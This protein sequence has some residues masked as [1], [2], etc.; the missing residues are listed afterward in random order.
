MSDETR[1]DELMPRE[2]ELQGL[3]PRNVGS[4]EWE[5][6]E[7]ESLE[8][9]LRQALGYFK[10]SVHGWSNE[11]WSQA[12]ESRRRAVRPVRR[13]VWRLAAAWSLASLLAITAVSGVVYERHQKQELAQ[14]EHDRLLEQQREMAEQR[15][16]AEEDLLA[17]VES[18]ISR[19]V[20][21][22]ME[23][24]AQLMASDGTQ[25][26]NATQ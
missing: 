25:T 16:R 21:S 9:E 20:P 13:R 1:N 8:P 17:K 23:P 10:A 22:A 14:I 2:R 18:D 11:V 24:L 7:P 15:Q 5:A 3:E 26:A 12:M 6:L 19:E 4:H